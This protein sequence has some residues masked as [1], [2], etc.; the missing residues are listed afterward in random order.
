[1]S[2]QAE[3][4]GSIVVI[5]NMPQISL[6]VMQDNVK[7]ILFLWI[8]FSGL[9]GSVKVYI[10]W[11]T[12]SHILCIFPNHPM[13]SVFSAFQEY[14]SQI[15]SQIT[16]DFCCMKECIE[17]QERN[18]LMFIEQEQKAAQQKI[19]ETIQQLTDIKAQAVSDE[20]KWQNVSRS[21]QAQCL[22]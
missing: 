20:M 11:D 5:L 3:S 21:S 15:K 16:K 17:R 7:Y 14:T 1:M 19:E 18:T 6:H 12:D 4:T 22:G 9:Q 8:K 2:C 10:R 13:N